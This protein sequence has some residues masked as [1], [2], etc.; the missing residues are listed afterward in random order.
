[1]PDETPTPPKAVARRKP[2]NGYAFATD[3]GAMAFVLALAYIHRES[4]EVT[5]AAI[6]FAAALLGLRLKNGPDSQGPLSA[7]L[8]FIAASVHHNA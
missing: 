5:Y 6:A 3:I 2:A 7:M 8:A 4:I 1:M